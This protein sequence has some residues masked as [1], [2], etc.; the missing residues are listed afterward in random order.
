M[1]HFEASHCNVT[2]LRTHHQLSQSTVVAIAYQQASSPVTRKARQKLSARMKMS[3]T[4]EFALD[5]NRKPSLL[6]GL[7]RRSTAVRFESF[8]HML[9]R[10]KRFA[11]SM[12]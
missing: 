11:L 7:A 3:A 5:L 4:S 9:T 1:Q 2:C 6:E 8:E 10:I 12:R